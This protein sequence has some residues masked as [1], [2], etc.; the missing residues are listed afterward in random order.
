M[1]Y[2]GALNFYN[3][4]FALLLGLIGMGRQ[5]HQRRW[6]RVAGAIPELAHRYLHDHSKHHDQHDHALHAV[7]QYPEPSAAIALRAVCEDC[8]AGER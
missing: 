4:Y 1:T 3:G 8:A 2:I 6:R 7:Q 5:W